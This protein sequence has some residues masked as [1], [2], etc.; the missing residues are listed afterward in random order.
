MQKSLSGSPGSSL[1]S[2]DSDD[3]SD[4]AISTV[5]DYGS[6]AEVASGTASQ[7]HGGIDSAQALEDRAQAEIVSLIMGE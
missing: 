2:F 3:G 5:G 6:A 1:P 4:S 7:G